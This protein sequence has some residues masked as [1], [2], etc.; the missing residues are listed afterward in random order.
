MNLEDVNNE[1][2]TV[3]ED[4]VKLRNDLMSE[5]ETYQTT[6]SQTFSTKDELSET[7]T[8]LRQEYQESIAGLQL[9]FSQ[10]YA[11]KTELEDAVTNVQATLQAQI[12][13]NANQIGEPV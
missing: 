7:E 12:T 13:V 8:T 11:K 5:I 9:T 2:G 4:A 6:A 3:K 10:D 1:I